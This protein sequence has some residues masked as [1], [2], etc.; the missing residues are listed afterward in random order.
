MAIAW[1]ASGP[2]RAEAIA[3]VDRH[4]NLRVLN[5]TPYDALEHQVDRQIKRR[6]VLVIRK[7]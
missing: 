3:L 5:T 6:D 7:E 2:K 4:P 1:E